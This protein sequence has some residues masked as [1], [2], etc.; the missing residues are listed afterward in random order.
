MYVYSVIYEDQAG[1]KKHTTVKGLSFFDAVMQFS[2]PD[3]M[4]DYLDGEVTDMIR[5]PIDV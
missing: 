1:Q 4:K 2:E 3:D 5:L